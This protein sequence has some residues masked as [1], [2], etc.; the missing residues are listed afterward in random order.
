MFPDPGRTIMSWCMK[1]PQGVG[2]LDAFFDRNERCDSITEARHASSR[3]SFSNGKRLRIPQSFR[4]CEHLLPHD[5]D[6]TATE[7]SR[8][9]RAK[10][11]D[12]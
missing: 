12:L 5:A 7:R 2:K 8:R 6:V 4:T 3:K 11:F 9:L 10:V 1:N